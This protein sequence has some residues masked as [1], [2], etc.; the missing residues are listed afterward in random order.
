[1]LDVSQMLARNTCPTTSVLKGKPDDVTA[2]VRGSVIRGPE[3]RSLVFIPYPWRCHLQFV[4]NPCPMRCGCH[5]VGYH[6]YGNNTMG[7]SKVHNLGCNGKGRF[8]IGQLV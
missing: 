4:P 2:S 3:K 5:F 1:M 8:K 7:T 6:G